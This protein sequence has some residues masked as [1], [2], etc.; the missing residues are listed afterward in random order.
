MEH[1]A[2][3]IKIH[4]VLGSNFLELV[5]SFF[6]GVILDL[7]IF[8]LSFLGHITWGEDVVPP[9]ITNVASGIKGFLYAH[10]ACPLILLKK[11]SIEV[12]FPL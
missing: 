10:R 11:F 1:L 5:N 9:P 4:R 6:C 2:A 12:A 7:K 3:L 8:Q